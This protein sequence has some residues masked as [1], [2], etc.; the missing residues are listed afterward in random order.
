MKNRTTQSEIKKLKKNE[1]FVFGSN[2]KGDHAGGA[3]SGD[4]CK[5]IVTGKNC[6]AVANGIES[7]AKGTKGN[8]L[9]LFEYVK[10]NDKWD[11]SEVKTIKIDGNKIK[12]DTFYQLING[13]FTEF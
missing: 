8:W 9:V 4:S 2:S 5:A 1:I 3:A 10:V 7:K 6:I 11:I 12:S 13:K